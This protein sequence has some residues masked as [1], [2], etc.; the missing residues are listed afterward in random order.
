MSE[1]S[2]TNTIT[3]ISIVGLLAYIAFNGI[4][5]NLK[6]D[7]CDL[8][9]KSVDTFISKNQEDS[10]FCSDYQPV[11]VI[12]QPSYTPINA[13]EINNK[14]IVIK[15]LY[16]RIKMQNDYIL[17]TNNTINENLQQYT[18]CVSRVSD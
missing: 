14:D 12:P 17:T 9:A 16:E 15:K 2:K 18:E 11:K 1:E 4:P 5:L 13:I 6:C 10:K 3:T 7:S 8:L